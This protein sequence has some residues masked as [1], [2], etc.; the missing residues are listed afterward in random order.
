MDSNH[1]GCFVEHLFA[2]ECTKRGFIVSM[3]VLHSCVYDCVID[4]N[5]NFFKIQIK[6]TQKKPI[7]NRKSVHLPLCNNDNKYNLQNVDWFCVY[8]EYYNGFFN[9]RNT[10][11]MQSIRLSITGKNSIYFNNFVFV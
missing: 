1:F 10:G 11:N 6:G 3:P 9:F 5:G 7:K 8:S 2:A 4:V